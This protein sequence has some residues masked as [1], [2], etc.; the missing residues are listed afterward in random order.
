MS[1]TLVGNI[2]GPKGDK[3]DPGDI[4]EISDAE[5]SGLIADDG[6]DT[7]AA[8]VEL[9]AGQIPDQDT[10]IGAA[11]SATIGEIAGSFDVTGQT[12]AAINAWLALP[13]KGWKRMVGA[14]TITAPLVIP[15]NTRVDATGA[16]ITST[17][18][19]NMVRN[20]AAT[21]LRNSSADAV[22]TADS[23]TVT[24]ATAAFTSADVGRAIAVS[25]STPANGANV[26]GRIVTV[27]SATSV[28][29]SVA[30]KTSQSGGIVYVYGRDENISIRGGKWMRNIGGASSGTAM[31]WGNAAHSLFFR[32]VDGISLSQLY[33]T[34]TGG[35]YAVSFGDC[36]AVRVTDHRVASYSDAMHFTGPCSDVVVRQ[37]SGA[38]GDDTVPFTT[39]DYAAYNDCH[40]D[41]RDISISDVHAAPATRLVLLATSASE[42]VDGHSIDRATVERVSGGGIYTEVLAEDSDS[43]IDNLT[44]RDSEGAVTL[45][46]VLHG[47]V[48]IE[49][50]VGNVV[51]SPDARHSDGVQNATNHVERLTLRNVTSE[52]TVVGFANAKSSIG[53]LHVSGGSFLRATLSGDRIDRLVFDSVTFTRGLAHLNCE[54]GEMLFRN[55]KASIPSGFSDHLVKLTSGADVGIITFDGGTFDSFSTTYGDLVRV[56]SGAVLDVL[57]VS[58]ATLNGCRCALQHSGAGSV[59]VFLSDVAAN[60][61][62]RLVQGTGTIDV[63]YAGVR[64]PG[65]LNAPFYAQGA[66]LTVRGTGFSGRTAASVGRAASE[67]VRVIDPA[68]PVDLAILAKNNGDA[69]NNTNAAL[70]CGV[71][72]AVSNGTNWKN[73]YSG[74]TY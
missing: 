2:T 42:A 24:S 74:T 61:C 5:V 45:R 38:S 26:Y 40:G 4:G 11:L 57:N 41:F 47:N 6:T 10:P 73:V 53:V 20:S 32:R 64:V 51:L 46:H 19:G 36:T 54:I 44:I 31:G 22:V 56:E 30:P 23:T 59:A 66:T 39:T 25:Y 70:A 43:R 48:V 34:S 72:P 3:G 63:T 67:V 21:A 12:T 29:V 37:V 28:T 55:V 17:F 14:V 50:H 1:K 16:E 35:K 13:F 18:V 7:N 49:N 15:S 9:V 52:D 68:M 8:A 58:R 71:G 69:A 65:A 33:F 60:N 62:S 27:N